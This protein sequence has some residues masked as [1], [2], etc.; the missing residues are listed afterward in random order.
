[1]SGAGTLSGAAGVSAEEASGRGFNVG[2]G[3]VDWP[4]AAIA[5]SRQA[6]TLMSAFKEV[7]PQGKGLIENPSIELAGITCRHRRLA[8][9]L[10]KAIMLA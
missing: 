10:G 6:T 3:E 1:V 7:P 4:R 5:S 8:E 2:A 9:A